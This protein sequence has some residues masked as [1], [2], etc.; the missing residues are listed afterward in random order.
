MTR[1]MDLPEDVHRTVLAHVDSFGLHDLS[2]LNRTFDNLVSPILLRKVYIPWGK[3][4]S[5]PDLC[6][7]L[8]LGL[9]S[10]ERLRHNARELKFIGS[11]WNSPHA[12]TFPA[13]F[14]NLIESVSTFSSLDSL[15][16]EW[17]YNWERVEDVEVEIND[18]A[19]KVATAVMTAT[20]GRLKKLLLHTNSSYIHVP[21]L[22]HT[23]T[24]LEQF[25]YTQDQR[26]QTCRPL[27][28]DIPRR[29][30]QHI[31]GPN[32][33]RLPSVLPAIL[34][35]NS[36]IGILSII[37]GCLGTGNSSEYY[38]APNLDKIHTFTLAGMSLQSLPIDSRLP[39]VPLRSLRHLSIKNLYSEYNL[40]LMWISLRETGTEL[41]TLESGQ[42]TS[43]VVDYLSS[44][45]GLEKLIIRGIEDFT[46]CVQGADRF[47][48]MV[49]P[50]HGP[51][52]KKLEL[53]YAQGV[54]D[55]PQWA[56]HPDRW[57]GALEHL[58]ALEELRLHVSNKA[59]PTALSLN[60]SQQY[61]GKD[62]DVH[63]LRFAHQQLLDRLFPNVPN[64]TAKSS[65]SP[66][67][68]RTLLPN[69]RKL[70]VCRPS[71]RFRFYGAARQHYREGYKTFM[72]SVV[73]V[74]RCR[75]PLEEFHICLNVHDSTLIFRPIL[76]ADLAA[77]QIAKEEVEGLMGGVGWSEDGDEKMDESMKEWFNGQFMFVPVITK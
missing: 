71:Y 32:C 70:A 43:S 38:L 60:L 63:Q 10:T 48:D 73:P 39:F 31:C 44:F 62:L 37:S 42:I 68:S 36:D 46:E 76:E 33:Q 9:F 25:Q 21:T 19:C 53:S 14:D 27:T 11:Y 28:D 49:L 24:G 75:K 72:R 57:A 17:I 45:S 50:I 56:F 26:N 7:T 52:L 65:D 77:K 13:A 12:F 29:E 59:L 30:S 51:T 3:Y 61:T 15:E 35:N 23:V 47:F 54:R 74:L 66:S 16:L 8:L 2:L 22:L 41:V 6:S 18:M 67:M 20:H 1:L 69:L 58:H 34:R 55:V 4:H 64:Y 40:D 5:D